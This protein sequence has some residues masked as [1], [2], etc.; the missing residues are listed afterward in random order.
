[1]S[2]LI[3]IIASIRSVGGTISSDGG[4]ITISAPAEVISDEDRVVLAEQRE[5]LIAILPHRADHDHGGQGADHD[6]GGQ[7]AYHEREAIRWADTPAAD[8]ALD[9][10]R[11]EWAEIV[12]GSVQ[13]DDWPELFPADL[14][15]L[16]G[17][18][19]YP[20][21]CPWCGGRT[22]HSQMCDELRQSW[23]PVMPFGK[24][25]GTRIDQIPRSYLAWMLKN[26]D[27]PCDL[28]EGIKELKA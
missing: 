27:L 26:A 18:R 20:R 6:H 14:E 3:E 13:S 1:M 15:Y 28:R 7:G 12:D 25:C 21:P 23:L 19:E 10:A 24:H 17:P 8:E 4:E 9:Q 22:C 16:L 11:R 5:T 2:N